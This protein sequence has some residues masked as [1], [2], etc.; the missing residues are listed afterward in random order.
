[1]N[2]LFAGTNHGLYFVEP[3]K[4]PIC[5]IELESIEY[6]DSNESG[7]AA[8]IVKNK[9]LFVRS[10]AGKWILKFPGDIISLKITQNNE[11]IAGVLP[12]KL[13]ISK[14]FLSTLSNEI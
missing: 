5:E 12:T 10:D 1:M 9:G 4:E 13:I 14:D 3:E 7:L 6:I 8:A 2:G 11:I